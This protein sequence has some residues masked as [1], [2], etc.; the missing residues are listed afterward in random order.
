MK[1]LG[2]L[3]HKSYV[4]C[5]GGVDSMAVV[6]FLMAGRKDIELLFFHHGTET[7]DIAF[8]FLM[9]FSD[10]NGIPLHVGRIG[11]DRIKTESMEEY[12][13]NERYG[14]F[15]NYSDRPIITCHHVGDQVENW[16][17]TSMHG[18]PMLIPH[19]NGNI[20]RPFLLADKQEF[21]HWCE[22]RSVAWV[23]DKSN[24]DVKY[25]RNRIRHNIV[26]EVEKINPGIKTVVRRLTLAKYNECNV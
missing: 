19:C 9:T 18:N 4:A 3:P 25:A 8:K 1:L 16:L 24:T 26:P 6:S 5:S 22:S 17:F 20:I 12:W 2:Q 7:S 11:R 13:R 15:K 10:T 14:F 21:I 23:E